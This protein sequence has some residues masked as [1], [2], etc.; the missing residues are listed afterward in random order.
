MIRYK[1]LV[2]KIHWLTAT[3]AICCLICILRGG[4]WI[5]GVSLYRLFGVDG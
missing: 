2:N 4:R 1:V 3:T 5:F